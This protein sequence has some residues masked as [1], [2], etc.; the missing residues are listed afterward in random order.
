MFI[1]LLKMYMAP[2]LSTRSMTAFQLHNEIMGFSSKKKE[3]KLI[4]Q[5]CTA[6]FLYFPE[7]A[8]DS[9]ALN[10]TALEHVT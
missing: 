6:T 3:V 2:G 4:D 5:V 7:H 10:R 1:S 9:N 8:N